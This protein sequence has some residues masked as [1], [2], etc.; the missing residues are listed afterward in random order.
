M[1]PGGVCV[2]EAEWEVGVEVIVMVRLGV[3]LACVWH[4]RSTCESSGMVLLERTSGGRSCR[5][6]AG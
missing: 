5:E 1:P 6:E 4:W 3:L 2:G